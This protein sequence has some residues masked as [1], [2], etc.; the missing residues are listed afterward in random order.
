MSDVI[1]LDAQADLTGMRERLAAGVWQ[2]DNREDLREFFMARYARSFAT[3]GASEQQHFAGY[4]REPKYERF[5]RALTGGVYLLRWPGSNR[6]LKS[7]TRVG[8]SDQVYR[9]TK[10]SATFG[11]R[12]PWAQDVHDGGANLFGEPQP[13]R[14][15]MRLGDP[16]IALLARI[17]SKL[18]AGEQVAPAEWRQR[19]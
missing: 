12:V 11:S 8:G 3:G 2:G 16:S 14:A 10:R 5:K 9:V 13:A 6:L 1:D 19:R 7:L 4:E 17:T 18:V 15:Y